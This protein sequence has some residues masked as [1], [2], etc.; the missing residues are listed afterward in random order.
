MNVVLLN[1]TPDP[2]RVVATAARLC[3]SKPTASELREKMTQD[4]INNL[5]RKVGDM[6][7][8]ST[9]EHVTF[10][11]AVDGI[12]RVLSHQ[13]VRHRIASYSQQSQRYVDSADKDLIV[14]PSI[15]ANPGARAI[16]DSITSQTDVAYRALVALG[17]PK[18]DA[19]Y[20]MTNATETRIIITM[21]ARVL[22]HFFNKR[23]CGRAQWEIRAMAQMM[24]R[25][26]RAVAP[27]IFERSGPHCV[28]E[29]VCYEG[30]LSCGYIDEGK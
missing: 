30:A 13:L 17:I 6:G 2:E 14:P 11:F 7:H 12:S 29:G 3:Y 23:C 20:V 10:T 25:Q 28:S 5:V 8:L 19:R 15:S 9:F 16:F 1:Y 4:D 26:V 21:N 22:L 18:E 24:L 27:V